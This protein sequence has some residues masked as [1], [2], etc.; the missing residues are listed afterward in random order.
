FLVTLCPILGINFETPTLPGKP[1]INP[2]LLMFSQMFYRINNYIF[3]EIYMH[4]RGG[5]RVFIFEIKHDK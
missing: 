4:V 2:L 1:F 3:I 5:A